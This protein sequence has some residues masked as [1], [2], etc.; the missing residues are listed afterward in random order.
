M[1]VFVTG[2]TGFVGFYVLQE[3]KSAGIPAVCLVRSPKQVDVF[4]RRGFETVIG[5]VNDPSSYQQAMQGCDAV[6]H[7]VAIIEEKKS[8]GIT[9][10]ALNV[11]STR[12]VLDA[13]GQAGI[14][15]FLYMSALGAGKYDDTP[16]YRTKSKAETLVQSSG[17]NYTIFRP[18]FIFGSGAPVYQMLAT[19][20][21]WSP[22]NVMPVFGSGE[23][24]QQPVSVF[25]VSQAVVYSLKNEKSYRKL[26]EI[27][28]PETLTYKEQIQGIG[29]AIDHSPRFFHLPL[30]FSRLMV[31][32][33][34]VFPFA[35]ID[36]DRLKMLTRDNVCDPSEIVHDLDLKL[37]PFS[38]GIRNNF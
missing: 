38:E 11:D 28:G 33:T 37:I 17:L 24:K 1:K 22:L 2:G 8:R 7:L 16:Y 19:L 26:Y 36:L 25:N 31:R 10:Q 27:G 23:Y 18:S 15:R 32:L 34:S 5:D 13:A 3:L 12:N 30:G 29:A 21:R 4:E 20:L 6:I 35:P 14:H 9:F